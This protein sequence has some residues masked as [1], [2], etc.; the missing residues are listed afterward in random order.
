ML[1]AVGLFL[2]ERKLS[3]DKAPSPAPAHSPLTTKGGQIL[4]RSNVPFRSCPK[5]GGRLFIEVERDRKR[6]P[7]WD[8]KCVNCGTT[9]AQWPQGRKAWVPFYTH[10]GQRIPNPYDLP[11]YGRDDPDDVE[12]AETTR[13]S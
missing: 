13:E 4:G 1:R 6:R 10:D 9:A 8:A 5:C 11:D 12:T 2:C 7:I 3:L